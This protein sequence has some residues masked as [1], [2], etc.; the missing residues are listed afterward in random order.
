MWAAQKGTRLTGCIH[1]TAAEDLLWEAHL[2]T[3]RE[4]ADFDAKDTSRVCD[5]LNRN[6][7][8]VVVTKDTV[9]QTQVYRHGDQR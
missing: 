2:R 4:H 8:A 6:G 3:I 1:Y 7:T 9:D 5:A